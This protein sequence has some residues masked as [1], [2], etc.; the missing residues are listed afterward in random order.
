[1]YLF[2]SIQHQSDLTFPATNYRSTLLMPTVYV[3]LN[4]LN[5]RFHWPVP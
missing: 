4:S 5:R 2:R 3:I 1:V